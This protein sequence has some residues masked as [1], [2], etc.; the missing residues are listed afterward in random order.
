MINVNPIAAEWI[1]QIRPRFPAVR[2]KPNDQ[3]TRLWDWPH[4]FSSIISY[5]AMPREKI[6]DIP[7][8]NKPK[9]HSPTAPCSIIQHTLHKSTSL[10]H[11]HTHTRT[12]KSHPPRPSYAHTYSAFSDPGTAISTRF[13]AY[14]IFKS[15]RI[16]PWLCNG[17]NKVK[18][19]SNFQCK[20]LKIYRWWDGVV[21]GVSKCDKQNC[22]VVIGMLNLYCL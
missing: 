7:R 14:V 16:C 19:E 1:P 5:G 22:G 13:N 20:G 6:Q 18:W 15:R 9:Q 12:H 8:R 4:L 3:S 17:W 10:S 11:T 21:T 2:T